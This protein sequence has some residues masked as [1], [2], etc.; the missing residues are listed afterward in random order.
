MTIS[1]VEVGDHDP[2]AAA[3]AAKVPMTLMTK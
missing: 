2:G 1:I 3:A